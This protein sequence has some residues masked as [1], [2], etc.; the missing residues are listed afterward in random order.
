MIRF[1]VY[2]NKIF[3][4][5]IVLFFIMITYCKSY[6]EFKHTFGNQE[7]PNNK[8]FGHYDGMISNYEKVNSPIMAFKISQD[9]ILSN[10]KIYLAY[11][12][13]RIP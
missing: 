8:Y 3:L 7:Y 5:E 13:L 10:Y 9:N 12:A 4:K 1:I 2:L 11:W 6:F